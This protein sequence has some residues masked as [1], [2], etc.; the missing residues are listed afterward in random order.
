MGIEMSWVGQLRGFPRETK[1]RCA[2]RICLV[3]LEVERWVR[4]Q[5]LICYR[6]ADETGRLDL[7]ER[8]GSKDLRIASL[9]PCSGSSLAGV[10]SRFPG[11]AGR[12]W[13]LDGVVG[14]D[15]GK[16]TAGGL[17]QIWG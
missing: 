15:E 3:P 1:P 9:L 14:R 11:G 4:R 8:R 6:A 10:A 17:L 7:E 13:R 5:L 16:A 2:T 12:S